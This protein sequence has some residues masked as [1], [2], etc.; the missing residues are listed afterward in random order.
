MLPEDL[1][2]LDAEREHVV[3]TGDHEDPAVVHERLR[4]A[5]I[6][7]REPGAAQVRAPDPFQPA[8][9]ARIER[10]GRGVAL[11][12]QVAAV[13]PP[14][15]ARRRHELRRGERVDLAPL[16]EK[17]ARREQREQA[18][19][20]ARASDPRAATPARRLAKFGR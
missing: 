13:G 20:P 9:V 6:L 5:R 4:L 14:S 7:R 1:A 12:V 19:G 18:E 8:D 17:G 11:V 2:G 15:V 3:R 10:A 16:R